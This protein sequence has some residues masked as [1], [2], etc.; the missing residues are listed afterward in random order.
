MIAK[1]KVAMIIQLWRE[2]SQVLTASELE[3]TLKR[4]VDRKTYSEIGHVKMK[5]FKV[6]TEAQ[7]QRIASA[8]KTRG[9]RR[10]KSIVKKLHNLD[11]PEDV[12]VA[13]L[14]NPSMEEAKEPMCFMG[15]LG[16][17]LQKVN[18]GGYWGVTNGYKVYKSK[19]RCEIPEYLSGAFKG[20][21][22]VCTL[23]G[24]IKCTRK[25]A[26]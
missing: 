18:D 21:K 12:Q 22:V 19:S 11:I 14:D 2:V 17:R 5:G 1:E 26:N 7:K 23:C 15:L 25:D 10:V 4:I 3:D 24:S 8:A 13:L 6:T 9:L 16:T 20:T